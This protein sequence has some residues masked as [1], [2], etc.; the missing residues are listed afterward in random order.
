MKTLL[1]FIRQPLIIGV[2]V[3][4]ILIAVGAYFGFY[5]YYGGVEPVP[6]ELLSYKLEPAV[7]HGMPKGKLSWADDS[8]TQRQSTPRSSEGK[9][10]S[11]DEPDNLDDFE[12]IPMYYF[13]DGT[14]VPEYLRCPEKWIGVYMYDLDERGSAEL[15]EHM[16]RVVDEVM[17][18]HNL[19]RPVAELWWPFIELE[20]QYQAD[21][22][23]DNKS[24]LSVAGGKIDLQYEHI[25]DF[26]E[27]VQLMEKDYNRWFNMWKVDRGD[28]DPDWNLHSLPDG[29]EFRTKD[30]Y[31]YEFH[32][33]TFGDVDENGSTEIYDRTFKV[34]QSEGG[35]LVV[36]NLNDTSDE[37]LER[38]GGWNYNYNPY[39]GQ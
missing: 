36:V 26:P 33:T 25:Y 5:W 18:N 31:R 19:N 38:I 29:R 34:S 4:S 28:Y 9:V 2:F 22:I 16:R 35:E 24:G 27:I 14:P 21:A 23:Q 12:D 37:E 10:Q 1:D 30:G 3:L 39:I 20:R 6:E 32:Y 13:P 15:E 17:T 7:S 11:A 8:A